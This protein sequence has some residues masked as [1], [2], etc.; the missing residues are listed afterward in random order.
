VRKEFVPYNVIRNNA[1]KLAYRIYREGFVPDVIYVSLR[2]GAYMG[3]VLSEYFKIVRK[4]SSRPVFYAAVVARSYTGINQ[5]EGI[6]IDGWTY[7]P[8]YLRSGDKVLIVDD[9]YDSGRTVNYLTEVILGKGLPRQDVKIAVHDYKICE[10][11]S[12]Q[13]SIAP[14]YW[15]RKHVIKDPADEIWIH[16]MSHELVGLTDEELEEH[17]YAEDPALREAFGPIQK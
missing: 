12:E 9:I 14:D 15:C 7:S 13:L 3:N 17:Y 4:D 2:G 10:Y 1:I 5:R 16:Y 6:R 11:R 8:K